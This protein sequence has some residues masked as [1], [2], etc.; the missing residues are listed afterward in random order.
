[1][2]SKKLETECEKLFN[3]K[4]YFGVISKIG[5]VQRKKDL[6]DIPL[7]LH[8]YMMKS[9]YLLESQFITDKWFKLADICEFLLENFDYDDL[10]NFYFHLIK[11]EACEYLDEFL[12]AIY[13]YKRAGMLFIEDNDLNL[14]LD[15]IRDKLQIVEHAITRPDFDLSFRENVKD[16]FE[17]LKEN[18]KELHKQIKTLFKKEEYDK[19]MDLV[20]FKLNRIFEKPLFH[21][22]LSKDDLVTVSFE[23]N[24]EAN[25]FYSY[26]SLKKWEGLYEDSLDKYFSF[27]IGIPENMPKSVRTNF[28]T[29]KVKDL[30]VNINRNEDSSLFNLFIYVPNVE[31]GYTEDDYKE[32]EEL[33]N[34]ITR[35]VK[36][37]LGE[38]LFAFTI[39]E[40][41]LTEDVLFEDESFSLTKLKSV[42]EELGLEINDISPKHCMYRFYKDYRCREDELDP[43]IK[44]YDIVKGHTI[45]SDLSSGFS[46]RVNLALVDLHRDNITAGFISFDREILD[47]DEQLAK[48]EEIESEI[49]NN[50]ED[51]FTIFPIGKAVGVKYCYIDFIIYDFNTFINSIED[52]LENIN[53]KNVCYQTF[54]EHAKEIKLK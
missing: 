6:I 4:D 32:Y 18:K 47:D 30:S 27:E 40:I 41:T 19:V 3:K 43:D 13:H 28:G 23:H 42:L 7:N 34:I 20:D 39:N 14:S 36:Y 15:D 48:L 35:L 52:V 26:L 51:P 24:M 54:T 10:D 49:F 33:Q 22:N 16:F 25:R 8:F 12:F 11:A 29:I 50:F 38:N 45:Y 5:D 1:M 17:D 53:I 46:D 31:Y 9:I 2:F 37:I 21:V 44:R